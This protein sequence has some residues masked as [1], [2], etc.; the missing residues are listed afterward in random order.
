MFD[1]DSKI[2]LKKQNNIM[3]HN[4][5]IIKYYRGKREG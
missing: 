2:S 3:Q 5:T 4:L 1:K